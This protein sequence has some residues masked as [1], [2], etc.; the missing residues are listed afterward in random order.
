M[1]SLKNING[2]T[3]LAG[4]KYPVTLNEK[5]ITIHFGVQEPKIIEETNELV[6]YDYESI[7]QAGILVILS[8]PITSEDT[9]FSHTWDLFFKIENYVGQSTYDSM[10]LQFK[11][12]EYILPSSSLFSF[13]DDYFKFS[14]KK[15]ILY[16]LPLKYK[17]FDLT[18]NFEI[19]S[20][21]SIGPKKNSKTITQPSVNIYFK[22]TDN[23]FFILELFEWIKNFFAFI[24]NRRN[25]D[26]RN[27]SLHAVFPSK[28]IDEN[29]NII[30]CFEKNNQILIPNYKYIEPNETDKEISKAPNI[31][32]F[33]NHLIEL[34]QLF[35]PQTI[36]KMPLADIHFIHESSK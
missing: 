22:N 15:T 25:I 20:K 33:Q 32:I 31:N 9:A 10:T 6:V 35:L 1:L 3:F 16:S 30:N 4:D 12:L 5:S 13:N 17:G 14:R 2:Y 19:S 7:G 27:A 26:L 36:D 28:R 29:H 34:F 21:S 24:C 8:V 18:I 11:E 23:P